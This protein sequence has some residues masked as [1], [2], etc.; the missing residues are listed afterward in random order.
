MRIAGLGDGGGG[1]AAHMNMYIES[2]LNGNPR[3]ADEAYGLLESCDFGIY[4]LV[5][6]DGIWTMPVKRDL[7]M[8]EPASKMDTLDEAEGDAVTADELTRMLAVSLAQ[9]EP[10]PVKQQELYRIFSNANM[11]VGTIYKSAIGDVQSYEIT[12]DS[13]MLVVKRTKLRTPATGCMKAGAVLQVLSENPEKRV[14]A[15]E[16]YE[17]PPNMPARFRKH[18]DVY[19]IRRGDCGARSGFWLRV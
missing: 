18:D 6:G 5:S 15:V 1:Q 13:V 19:P 4:K 3:A 14:Y 16:K 12:G 8:L 7:S 11:H 9:T 10:D 2:Y 17:M